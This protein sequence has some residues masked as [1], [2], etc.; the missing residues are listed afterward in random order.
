MKIRKKLKQVLSLFLVLILLSQLPVAANAIPNQ[1]N[2]IVT[3]PVMEEQTAEE[4]DIL[5]ELPA[6]RDKYTKR[7]LLDN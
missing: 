7:F 3:E 6:E 5:T 4:P 1:D 2:I